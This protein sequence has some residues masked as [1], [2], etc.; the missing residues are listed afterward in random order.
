MWLLATV[1]DVIVLEHP[2]AQQIGETLD[3]RSFQIDF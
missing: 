3:F 2:K 1:R